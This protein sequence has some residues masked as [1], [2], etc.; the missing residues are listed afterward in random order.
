LYSVGVTPLRTGR[1]GYALLICITAVA[2]F[3]SFR[4]IH[5]PKSPIDQ[6]YSRAKSGDAH[7]QLDYG[8]KLQRGDGV[9]Q[10]YQQAIEWFQKAAH[11]GY[12][13]AYFNLGVTYMQGIGVSPVPQ[14]AFNW[15]QKAAEVNFPRAQL[16]LG[17]FYISGFGVAADAALAKEWLEKAAQNGDPDA[18][19]VLH[20]L[21]SGRLPIGTPGDMF[22]RADLQKEGQVIAVYGKSFVYQAGKWNAL[23]EPPPVQGP[24]A[25]DANLEAIRAYHDKNYQRAFELLSTDK[26]RYNAYGRYLLGTLYEHGWGVR[27]DT[28][29][30]LRWYEDA[31]QVYE[32]HAAARLGEIYWNGELGVQPDYSRAQGY[33]NRALQ[34]GDYMTAYRGRRPFW[35]L[36][37]FSN[38][39]KM[40]QALPS[41]IKQADMGDQDAA[42]TV[43]QIC[44]TDKQPEHPDCKTYRIRTLAL[45]TLR[46]D[47]APYQAALLYCLGLG[48]PMDNAKCQEWLQVAKKSGDGRAAVMLSPNDITVY[49]KADPALL[50]WA[51]RSKD[52]NRS[53]MACAALA[54]QATK[55]PAFAADLEAAI[56]NN[57]FSSECI[58]AISS[59]DIVTDSMLETLT[60]IVTKGYAPRPGYPWL[61]NPSLYQTA[62]AIIQLV[63]YRRDDPRV[64]ETLKKAASE[65]AEPNRSFAAMMLDPAEQQRFFEPP[66]MNADDC[67]AYQSLFPEMK[68]PVRVRPKPGGKP[69]IGRAQRVLGDS[70]GFQA[71]WTFSYAVGKVRLAPNRWGFIRTGFGQHDPNSDATLFT[72]DDQCHAD[73]GR[74]M[75]A[76]VQGDEGIYSYTESILERPGRGAPVEIISRNENGEVHVKKEISYSLRRY[77]GVDFMPVQNV[78]QSKLKK[79]FEKLA[80]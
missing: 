43:R 42:M 1:L 31:A 26:N 44:G 38:P 57:P 51:L 37:L 22:H 75:L 67:A 25:P 55:A 46:I 47:K 16:V 40:N 10:D 15:F 24:R 28:A 69:L 41:L 49:D 5:K 71:R 39:L 56:R 72:Y 21:T 66:G 20:D 18:P 32:Y 60:A 65:S 59:V 78:P 77:D 62:P 23:K 13:K 19:K 9:A 45:A 76:Q 4:S 68:L 6:L 8:V 73:T 11:Q 61:N 35:N 64:R 80:R 58:D 14:A 12:D 54:R 34:N 33:I 50:R 30:A 29:Q 53:R 74:Q 7:A 63:K 27:A 17:Q 36:P 48:A 2:A 70:G 79:H 3:L 52:V